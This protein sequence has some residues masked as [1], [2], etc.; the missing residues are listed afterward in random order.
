MRYEY[1]LL[2]ACVLFA[3]IPLAQG[4]SPYEVHALG[5]SLGSVSL[6]ATAWLLPFAWA[7]PSPEEPACG[8]CDPLDVWAVDRP[9]VGV[10]SQSATVWSDVFLGL[11]FAYPLS[12][13]LFDEPN[14][15][16]L[17]DG[18]VYLETAAIAF[19]L[20]QALKVGIGRPR[21][22]TYNPSLPL[23]ARSSRDAGYS[24]PSGHASMSFALTLAGAYTGSLRYPDVHPGIFYS[25][26]TLLAL[27]T[28]SLR[29]PAGKHFGS[30]VLV[31][32]LLGAAIG[33]GV[34]YL[35]EKA[36]KRS[37]AQP[38]EPGSRQALS[39]VSFR[40]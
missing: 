27:T 20:T 15:H 6:L 21:P 11:A 25:T 40:W 30:D 24:F 31:G 34:P 1:G 18:V 14:R 3:R 29:L 38:P 36:S 5:E 7:P 8:T 33:L 28:A 35:H 13:T 26:A 32:A 17:N 19:A 39:I 12:I 16:A 2:L 9:L 23:E 4:E 10:Y 37:G 22:L